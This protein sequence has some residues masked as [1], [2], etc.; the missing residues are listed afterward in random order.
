VRTDEERLFSLAGFV[1]GV[2]GVSLF[3]SRIFESP[4]PALLKWIGV[5]AG[6]LLAGVVWAA[7]LSLWYARARL[8]VKRKRAVVILATPA[9]PLAV[10]LLLLGDVAWTMDLVDVG[11]WLGGSLALSLLLWGMWRFELWV[12][13][14]RGRAK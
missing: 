2:V 13:R 14:R 5:A 1:A 7:I 8:P 3:T 11:V 9:L 10:S 4:W 12:E 6:A